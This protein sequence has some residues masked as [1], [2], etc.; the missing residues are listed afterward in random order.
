MDVFAEKIWILLPEDPRLFIMFINIEI[1]RN[2]RLSAAAGPVRILE[3]AV[4]GFKY[5]VATSI[6]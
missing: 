4:G 6:C 3:I 1:R 2:D 5:G